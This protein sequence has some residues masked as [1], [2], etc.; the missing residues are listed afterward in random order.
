[1]NTR[2]RFLSAGLVSAAG[3]A[4]MPAS[5]AA[6]TGSNSPVTASLPDLAYHPERDFWNDWPAFIAAKIKDARARR[7]AQLAQI[8]TASQARD[9]SQKIRQ[10][11]WDILG[12]PPEKTPL[13]AKVTHTRD[14]GY[15]RI[16]TLIF[17]SIPGVYVTANLY[18]PAGGS[19][20]YPAILCPVGHADNGKAYASYQHYFQNLA[21]QGFIVLA[22]DPWGQGER[23]QYPDAK[24]GRSRF[25]PTGEHSQ[26]G[27]P[28]ILLGDGVARYLAWD[29]IR[30]L[31]YLLSLPE[32]DPKRIGCSGHSGGG[33][34]TMYLACLEPRIQAAVTIQG[35]F[36]NLAGPHFDPPGSIDDA[37][38]NIVGGLAAGLDRGD[39]LSAFAPKPLLMCYTVHDVG[40]TYS[41]AY[42]EATEEI[43][44]GLQRVY[45]VFGQR[46][47]VS[48]F[49]GNLPHDLDYFSRRAA[50]KWFNQ[51]LKDGATAPEESG[52]D[53]FPEELLN[54]TET[55]QVLAVPGCRPA[56]QVNADRL[57]Q[58]LPPGRFAAGNANSASIQSD[59]RE[60]L[61]RILA[62]PK[63][64]SPLKPKVVSS[65]LRKEILIEEIQFHSEPGI[66]IPAWFLASSSTGKR[67]PTILY[68]AEN[69]GEDVIDEPGPMGRILAQGSSVCA[70]TLRGLGI[71]APCMPGSGPNYFGDSDRISDGFPWA[72][73]ALGVP[74]I[75]QWVWDIQR[76]IDYLALRE[77]VDASQIRIIAL[78]SAGIAAQLAA[79]LDSRVRSILLDRTLA[80]YA[81]LVESADYSVRIGWF[82]PGILRHFDLPDVAAA[83]AP[84][85]CWLLNATG[86]TD[87][88]LTEST[89]RD[90][91]RRRIG[92][93]SSASAHLRFV[94][95]A[96]ADP[97]GTYVEWLRST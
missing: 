80:S 44:S 16:D 6:G 82:V 65:N 97:Q 75:G 88:V 38:Q 87:A 21:R 39:L 43:F 63:V 37:E 77:D 57:L 81:S 12:G 1:M 73:L 13:N 25:G 17:E 89:V 69:G 24:T 67:R 51:W 4:L 60:Q 54:A 53:I 14:R 32:V 20:P 40:E 62:L 7:E 72:S 33:T 76:A 68:I 90:A 84:R 41:P 66:R 71:S 48:L 70:I 28:M 79:L 5:L 96:S 56:V 52:L 10:V 9:R 47:R 74:A 95:D 86:P 15:C 2:R 92:N 23:F 78:G 91:Y 36:E 50:Y 35:N 19:A 49:T 46:D 31:D 64:T 29:G 58:I 18:R 42:K 85:A 55:G 26:A 61:L 27:R 59:F 45:G 11:L 3:S 30:A 22:Y 93:N 34:M 8:R 94:A 83:L